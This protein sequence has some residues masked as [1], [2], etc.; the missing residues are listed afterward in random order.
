MPILSVCCELSDIKPVY[1]AFT[2]ASA[3][4]FL[5]LVRD[6]IFFARIKSIVNTVRPKDSRRVDD[7]NE[8][9]FSFLSRAQKQKIKAAVEL[10]DKSTKDSINLKMVSAG[11]AKEFIYD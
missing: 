4:D 5:D 8:N 7:C 1:H 3:E 9:I 11:H 10:I 6:R 2:K